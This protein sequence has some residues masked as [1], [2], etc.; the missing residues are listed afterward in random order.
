MSD[1]EFV[2]FLETLDG[3]NRDFV[4][5][6]DKFLL[7]N[8][9]KR[10]IKIAKSGHLVSYIFKETK[11]TL[12]NFVCRKT[13]VKI[14]IYPVNVNKYEDFLDTL[15]AKMKKGIEK[16]SDC[17]RLLN[18]D[19]CNPKCAMGYDFHM[20]SEHYQKCRN[21]AFMHDLNDENNAYIK[22]FL[23]KEIS[24]LNGTF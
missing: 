7:E 6:I 20:D 13:G 21:M 15:P 2:E 23:E 8:G 14:R 12:V 22:T 9:C 5:D 18:P 16:S 19:A 24:I 3:G 17:K 10:E 4:I 1:T 11:K